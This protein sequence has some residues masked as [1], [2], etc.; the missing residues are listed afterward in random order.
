MQ[1]GN[2]LQ[3][4]SEQYSGGGSDVADK[5]LLVLVVVDES[6]VLLK[7]SFRPDGDAKIPA[8][9]RRARAIGSA[10]SSPR[11]SCERLPPSVRKRETEG[12]GVR[13]KLPN[14]G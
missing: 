4:T 14:K 5:A 7:I 9:L 6:S 12:K 13:I 2:K 11:S 3:K 1:V 8:A 10:L